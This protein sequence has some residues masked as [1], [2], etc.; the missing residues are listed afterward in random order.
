MKRRILIFAMSYPPQAVGT[1]SYAYA[2]ACGLADGGYEPLVVAPSVEGDRAF[3][4]NCAFAVVRFALPRSVPMR[5]VRAR[6]LLKKQ[7]EVFAPDCTWA[8]NG[9]A[10]RVAGLLDCWNRHP[11]ITSMRGS[12]VVIHLGGGGVLR[13]I[14]SMLQRRAYAQSAAIAAVSR[15][16]RDRAVAQG[17]DGRSIF[18][19]PPAW[20]PQCA[21]DYC[22]DPAP[23]SLQ[24]P[25]L[26]GKRIVLTVARLVAQKRVDRV[27]Q[28]GSRLLKEFPD[29]V[30]V[31]VG[32]GPERERLER[33]ARELGWGDRVL[34]VGALMPRSPQLFDMYSAAEVFMLPSVREGM[35]NVFIEAGAFGLPCLGVSDGG[36]PECIEEGKSGLL[37]RVDDVE[38][39]C[40]K[41]RFILKDPERARQMGAAGRDRVRVAFSEAALAERA[42]EVMESV[43]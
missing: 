36:V 26:K 7:V 38:D 27:L 3:D 20:Q 24:F 22:Y 9:M 25:M 29:M 35:G 12:D 23:L 21:R 11:L 43:C 5:Y 13:E 6:A 15:F 18:V 30:Q 2:L 19:H 33:L 14:E 40:A 28:A 17:V 10:T 42:I 16:V 8:T 4:A 31:I 39:L 1:G 41:L 34:F 37:C 32:D